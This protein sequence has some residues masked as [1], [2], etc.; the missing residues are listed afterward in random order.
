MYNTCM[1]CNQNS[2]KFFECVTVT[3]FCIFP[4]KV[5]T[6]IDE[7][8]KHVVDDLATLPL[9]HL[10]ERFNPGLDDWSPAQG[11]GLKV[12]HPTS[13]HSGRLKRGDKEQSY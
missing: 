5:Q 4:D 2:E 6:G 9:H 3:Y 11:S 8:F 10:A 12:H 7:P 1:L 13:T